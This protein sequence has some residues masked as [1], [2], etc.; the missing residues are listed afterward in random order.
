M[1]RDDIIRMAREAGAVEWGDSVIPAMMDIERFAALVAE[2]ERER[3]AKRWDGLHERYLKDTL[4]R[5][6][7]LSYELVA[8]MIR[9]NE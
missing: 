8:K 6:M 3:I 5:Q 4:R 7:M 2:A 9:G 1:N